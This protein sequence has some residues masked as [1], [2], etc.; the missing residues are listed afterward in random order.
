MLDRVPQQFRELQEI[1]MQS[2][3]RDILAHDT[4]MEGLWGGSLDRGMFF[5]DQQRSA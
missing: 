2:D 4:S 1:T 3:T 5:V